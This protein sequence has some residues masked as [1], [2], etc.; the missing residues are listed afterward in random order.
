VKA[1]NDGVRAES[2]GP[3][4]LQ[5]SMLAGRR[6]HGSARVRWAVALVSSPSLAPAW[7]GSKGRNRQTSQRPRVLRGICSRQRSS[8]RLTG[9]LTSKGRRREWPP[10]GL[11]PREGTGL[12]FCAFPAFEPAA[13]GRVSISARQPRS[14]AR[15]LP[16]GAARRRR[17]LRTGRGPDAARHRPPGHAGP[18]AAWREGRRLPP[19][20]ELRTGLRLAEEEE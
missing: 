20:G 11:S 8:P 9:S 10:A 16:A 18:H 17:R 6:L 12:F 13:A 2:P 1:R 4:T 7:T 5:A 14:R 19:R 15:R 3:G